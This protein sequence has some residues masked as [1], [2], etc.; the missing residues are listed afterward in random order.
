MKRQ[1]FNADGS[2]GKKKARLTARGDHQQE[3]RDF[4]KSLLF[5]PVIRLEDVRSLLAFAVTN[6]LDVIQMDVDSAFL[7]ATLEEEVYMR[8]PEGFVYPDRPHA[9]YR[10]CKSLYGLRQAPRMWNKE[11]H[12]YLISIGF[13]RISADPCVYVKEA[14]KGIVVIGLYVDELPS[15]LGVGRIA[16]VCQI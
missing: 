12:E 16:R 4:F 14:E 10:L 7:Q 1:K 9:V 8:Q 6:D 11:I 13:E 5:A 15:C 3:G 2:P